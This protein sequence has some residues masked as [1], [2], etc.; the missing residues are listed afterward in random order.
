MPIVSSRASVAVTAT[1]VRPASTR[2]GTTWCRNVAPTSGGAVGIASD[3]VAVPVA[4]NDATSRSGLTCSAQP[5]SACG[6]GTDNGSDGTTGAR[7]YTPTAKTGDGNPA[8]VAWNVAP[9]HGNCVAVSVCGAPGCGH[10]AAN[11]TADAGVGPGASRTL[12]IACT[13]APNSASTLMRS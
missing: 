7:P 4:V 12:S 8:A 10:P 11:A 6:N 3:V 13:S 5:G 1:I 9:S 2:R